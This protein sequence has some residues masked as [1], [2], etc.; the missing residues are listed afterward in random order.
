VIVC[1]SLS[2]QPPSTADTVHQQSTQCSNAASDDPQP[3]RISLDCAKSDIDDDEMSVVQE[4][5]S[6]NFDSLAITGV[7]AVQAASS[8]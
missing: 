6:S 5:L 8:S 4:E 3:M 7:T 2:V 1:Q